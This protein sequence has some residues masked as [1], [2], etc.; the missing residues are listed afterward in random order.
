[1]LSRIYC[2]EIHWLTSFYLTN[3]VYFRANHN[4]YLLVQWQSLTHSNSPSQETIGFQKIIDLTLQS[5]K[6]QV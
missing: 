6:L 3:Y 2:F 4:F 5:T 1:M